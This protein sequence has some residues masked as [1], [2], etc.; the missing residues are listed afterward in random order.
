MRREYIHVTPT[1]RKG[2]SRYDCVF[3]NA[4]PDL[5]GMRGLE[6]ACV[7]LFFSFVHKGTHYPGA[8]VQWYSI[9]GDEPDDETGLCIRK[10][11]NY[12]NNLNDL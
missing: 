9:I 12:L 5:P 4:W 2:R 3:V 6:V 7:F 10:T 11:C 8:L 1:W